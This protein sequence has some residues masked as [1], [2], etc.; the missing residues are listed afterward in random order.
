[1]RLKTGSSYL[2]LLDGELKLGQLLGELQELISSTGGAEVGNGDERGAS[3]IF[4]AA[5]GGSG[6]ELMKIT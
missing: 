5:S 6:I 4:S 1:M 2:Q 3:F